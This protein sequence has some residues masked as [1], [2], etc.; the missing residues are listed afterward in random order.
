MTIVTFVFN[1]CQ[2]DY[3]KRNSINKQEANAFLSACQNQKSDLFKA[4]IK[5]TSPNCRF[6]TD[7]GV[8]GSEGGLA[9]TPSLKLDTLHR[10][11]YIT[12][13]DDFSG[14]LPLGRIHA[15]STLEDLI[16]LEHEFALT[17]ST[18]RRPDSAD[19]IVVTVQDTKEALKPILLRSKE[20]LYKKGFSDSEI[21]EMIKEEN[22]TE[23]D[24]I[25]LVMLISSDESQTI[26]LHSP[27]M[28]YSFFATPCYA[29]FTQSDLAT[30]SKCALQA[31]GADII[32]ALC[33]QKGTV[34]AKPLIK[35]AFKTVAKRMLGP[36]GVG[37][38]VVEFTVCI[39]NAY[40]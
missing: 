22:A 7:I 18:I 16:R 25:A 38:A 2:E 24:L 4:S 6:T 33:L 21:Q 30:I 26:A 20:Y 28:E 15:A 36:I 12:P 9:G 23:E 13:P 37:I 27:N 39:G 1:A 14:R 29:A 31:I 3:D 32:Q 40:L 17:F 34:W 5:K 19:S 8:S 35:K 11:L 10:T